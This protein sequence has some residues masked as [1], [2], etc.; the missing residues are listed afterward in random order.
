MHKTERNGIQTSP[1]GEKGTFSFIELKVPSSSASV[2]F[3]LKLEL[4]LAHERKLKIEAPST[5]EQVVGMI[6]ILVS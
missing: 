3:P 5:W 6:K 1:V 2:S 4:L